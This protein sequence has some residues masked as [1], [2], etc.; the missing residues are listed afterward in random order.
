MFLLL[1]SCTS[2]SDPG[3][4]AT[5]KVL[6]ENYVDVAIELQFTKCWKY[7]CAQASKSMGACTNKPKNVD[8]FNFIQ[9]SCWN[10]YP[11]PE[12]DCT[13]GDL[14]KYFC[15]H[16]QTIRLWRCRNHNQFKIGW[17]QC[18]GLVFVCLTGIHLKQYS[19]TNFRSSSQPETDFT[20]YH[21][22]WGVLESCSP[23]GSQSGIDAQ[24]YQN[25]SQRLPVPS[26]LTKKKGIGTSGR[27]DKMEN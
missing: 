26:G 11:G 9:V 22:L 6:H 5:R 12:R 23:K 27:F 8:R 3:R 17:D 10:H 16:Y 19:R 18:V 15:H 7:V 25:G 4:N 13:T 21:D 20:L 24:K 14:A 1:S 2:L